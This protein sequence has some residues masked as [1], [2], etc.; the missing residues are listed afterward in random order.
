MT[1]SRYLRR[2]NV[3]VLRGGGKILEADESLRIVFN[4]RRDAAPA[5]QPST[6]ALY[7]LSEASERLISERG[8]MVRLEAGYVGDE[9]ALVAEGQIRRIDHPREGLDRISTIAIGQSD[10]QQATIF[11][12]SYKGATLRLIVGDI[13]AEMGLTLHPS[14]SILPAE[15]FA[16]WSITARCRDALTELLHPRGIRWYELAGEI[17]FASA[18]MQGTAGALG[19]PIISEAS[20]MIGSPAPT[21]KGIRVKTLLDPGIAPNQTIVVESEAINGRYTVIVVL[22]RGDTRENGWET[23]I[24]AIA[25]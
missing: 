9:L 13:V 6:I 3:Q 12:R 23:E 18:T 21:E 25:A 20:G 19:I 10:V 24:E 8:D 22:H 16:E 14:V 15:T 5:T 11:H 7:N 17:G 4:I 2:C 1:I